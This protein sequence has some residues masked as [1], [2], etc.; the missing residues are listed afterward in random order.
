MTSQN[1]CCENMTFTWLL[2]IFP[3]HT[4]VCRWMCQLCYCC[5]ITQFRLFC[6]LVGIFKC[7]WKTSLVNKIEASKDTFI[8]LKFVLE[9]AY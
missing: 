6:L 8:C 2:I 3:K 1:V 5:T 9:K 7:L 4:I